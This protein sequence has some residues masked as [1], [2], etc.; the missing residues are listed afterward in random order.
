MAGAPYRWP[1]D[2]SGPG[3]PPPG[4]PPST[5][6]S[7]SLAVLL[8]ILATG[9]FVAVEFALVAVDRDRVEVDAAAGSRAGPGDRG[10]APAAVV[11]PLGRPAR[12]HGHVARARLHRRAD[13]RRGPRA[14]GRAARGRGPGVGHGDRPRPRARHRSSTM[15]LGE[16]VP[17]S[18]AIA[19]PRADRLRAG[20]ADARDHP[21]ARP[22]HH[23]SSTAPP[24]GPCAGSASSRRRS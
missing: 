5:P 22:A 3:P 20:G 7:A 14:A 12:H 23:G 4:R 8:L 17:K 1:V 2:W 18:I 21:R 19:R 24:T 9:F 16:L 11:Q 13:D 10:R 6:R 15:V